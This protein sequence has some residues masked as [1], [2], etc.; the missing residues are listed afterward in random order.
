M[1]NKMKDIKTGMVSLLA[2]MAFSACEDFLDPNE[3]ALR[4]EDKVFTI[5]TY[6]N[7]MPFAIYSCVPASTGLSMSE[8]TDEGDLVDASESYQSFNTGTWNKY[9][10][11]DDQW[12]TL[13]KG[14]RIA[15]DYLNGTDT[16]TWSKHRYSYP[17]K[18]NELMLNLNIGRAEAHFLRAYF[19]FELIKR[20]GDV[21]L[22]TEDLTLTPDL[23][24]SDFKRESVAKI[25]DYICDECDLVSREGRYYKSP[26]EIAQ[27]TNNG[28]DLLANPYRDTLDIAYPTTGDKAR[29]LGR[30]TRASAYAL[31]AKTLIYFASKQYNP[32]GDL[33]R[34]KKAAE[35]CKK[36]LELPGQYYKLE[37]NY[38]DI[39]NKKS[40]WSKEFLFVRKSGASNSFEKEYYP[41]SIEGGKTTFC[42]SQNLVDAYEVIV[43]ENT[44]VPFD[45]TNPEHKM[46]PYDNRDPRFYM[47]IYKHGDLYDN[48]VNKITLDCAEGGNSA[49][50]I[51]RATT[52]GYYLKKYVNPSLDLKNNKTDTKTWVLMR[53][54]DFYLYYA[55]AMNEVYGPTSAGE[56]DMNALAALNEVRK[57]AGMPS[58]VAVNKEQLREKIYNERRVEL[59]FENSRWWDIRRWNYGQA[60][61]QDLRGVKVTIGHVNNS[62]EPFV[63]EKRV[64][65]ESKMYLYPISQSEI[66]KS[67]G[68]L[69]QNPNW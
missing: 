65:D 66:D 63:V 60:F 23:D 39:F 58:V 12:G 43:D 38:A 35:A 51:Y 47:S 50:P 24:F 57:R 49:L 21:P 62:Y 4:E 59:A 54:A 15:C 19:Y 32:E 13:Y 1:K 17:D 6:V 26:E 25:V 37:T 61:N 3:Y 34:W 10:N 29:F 9:S 44:S 67:K 16:L 52:T 48:V 27:M 11:P 41:V 8:A 53:L 68:N 5:S 36:V 56:F 40:S 22:I 7:S 45:W 55:E 18:Y 28:R 14:I 31:K 69:V 33:E 20:Y 64:F 2:C 46:S 42:P 30:A